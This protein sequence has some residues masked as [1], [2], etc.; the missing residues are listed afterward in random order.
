MAE[1][2]LRIFKKQKL[3]IYEFNFKTCIQI[4]KTDKYK[5]TFHRAT[6]RNPL[7]INSSRYFEFEDTS[8]NKDPKFEKV[9]KYCSF[10]ISVIEELNGQVIVRKFHENVFKDTNQKQLRIEKIIKR[11]RKQITF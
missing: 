9:A 4:D 3:D 8:N 2:M 11:K 1:K 6:K 7:N 5:N 10:N